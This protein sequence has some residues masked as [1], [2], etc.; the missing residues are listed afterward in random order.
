VQDLHNELKAALWGASSHRP[1][2]APSAR[3]RSEDVEGDPAAPVEI[4]DEPA[5]D[6]PSPSAAPLDAELRREMGTLRQQLD[7][8][9]EEVIDRV[10]RVELRLGA[11]RLNTEAQVEG[12]HAAEQR[13]ANIIELLLGLTGALEATAATT[14]DDQEPRPAPGLVDLG[15]VD[16]RLAQVGSALSEQLIDSRMR[17]EEGLE[18]V[19]A[20]LE[21]FRATPIPVNTKALE[22]AADRGSLRNAA[23]IANLR[24][25][26]EALAESVRIQ[27]RGL[28]E[29]RTTLDWIKERLLLR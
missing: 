5:D 23:D 20:Q 7:A 8:A 6:V 13:S 17:L 24:R 21:A 10:K 27:D 3:D 2:G 16:E 9:F 25:N 15:P 19:R 14:G 18:Q 26:I 1:V 22:D 4:A 28:S 11:I 12:M 29:L